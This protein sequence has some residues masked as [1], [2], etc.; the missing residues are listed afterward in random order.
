MKTKRPSQRFLIVRHRTYRHFFYSVLSQWVRVNL[1]HL[2]PWFHVRNLPMRVKD[3]SRYAMHVAWLQDP[4]QRWSPKTYERAVRLADQC[5]QC[6]IPVVNR[7]DRLINA[8]KS[9]GAKLMREAGV[10]VARMAPIDNPQEFQETLLGLQLPLFIR[11]D[12]GHEWRVARIDTRDDLRNVEWEKFERPL[13]VEI[14]DVRNP[15]DGLYRKYRYF[16]AGE[17]GISHHLQVSNEW[18][19]RGSH[20]LMRS[21]TRDEELNYIS[22]PDPNHEILQR[23]RRALGL[24]L[25]AFDYGYTQ[26]GQIIIW[27]ANPFPHLV[28]ATRRLMYKNPALHRSLLAMVHLYFS[29][30][31][32]PVPAAVEDGLALDFTALDQ[33]FQ[34]VQETNVIGR[35]LAWHRS[36]P[37]WPD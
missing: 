22:Q 8:T 3:W 24:D 5:D 10:R 2:L 21:E 19:T 26:D 28:F 18:I 17:L 36:F 23:A 16:A 34:I 15:W 37:K 30:A 6:G 13:A 7:V 11:E 4:V 29:A 14:V 27:E 1:P 35:L 12:W 9:R 33:H 25:V 32:L 31:R 20:R